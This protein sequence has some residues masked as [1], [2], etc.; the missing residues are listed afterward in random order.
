MALSKKDI[1]ISISLNEIYNT[2]ALLYQHIDAIRKPND[3][4]TER[5][6]AS[7]AS[8]L[9]SCNNLR[10]LLGDLGSAPAQLSRSDNKSLNLAL[11]SKWESAP[12]LFPEMLDSRKENGP[13][14]SG[15]LTDSDILFMD[16]KTLIVQ[17]MRKQA[18]LSA[19]PNMPATYSNHF[20]LPPVTIDNATSQNAQSVD[21]ETILDKG[22]SQFKDPS[23][24]KRSLR[25]K[26]NLRILEERYHHPLV[27]S[28]ERF[29]SLAREIYDEFK[30]LNSL[31]TKVTHEIKSLELVYKTICDHNQY[32]RSQLE[33]Y[34]AYLQNVRIQASAGGNSNSV[35]LGV[36]SNQAQNKSSVS[37]PR[38]LISSKKSSGASGPIK[39]SHAQLEKDGVIVESGVPEVRRSNIY[40][41]IESP[42]PGSFMI[43]LHYKGRDKPIVE[44]DIKLDDLLEKQQDNIQHLDLEY[45]QLNV[46][47]MLY[48][49]NKHFIKR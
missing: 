47:K 42:V 11:F 9:T 3:S 48:M 7:E 18:L 22:S 15:E 27:N 29:R 8:Y 41:I 46:N 44:V 31:Q 39:F 20:Y 49:L 14:N 21:I 34:R 26:Q 17:I 32:L 6:K 13:A 12:I 24:V 35:M 37:G 2:H 23:T 36:T 25:A 16:T 38:K 45:V 10:S 43:S 5:H 28:S 1:A 30:H 33:S 40:F 4:S 19:A